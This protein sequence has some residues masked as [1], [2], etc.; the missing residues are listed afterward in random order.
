M[1]KKQNFFR[2]QINHIKS[3]GSIFIRSFGM[4]FMTSS[5]LM[6][7][8]FAFFLFTCLQRIEQAIS[9]NIENLSYTLAQNYMVYDSLVNREASDELNAYMDKIVN[10]ARDF[11]VIAITLRNRQCLYHPNKDLIGKFLPSTIE[12]PGTSEIYFSGDS[13]EYIKQLC[14]TTPIINS[15]NI[16]IGYVMVGI[17]DKAFVRLETDF[18]LKFFWIVI[19]ALLTNAF[20]SYAIA[21][22][23]KNTLFGYEPAHFAQLFIQRSEVVDNMEEGIFAINKAGEIIMCNKPASEMLGLKQEP[24][25]GQSIRSLSIHDKFLTILKSTKPKYNVEITFGDI[26]LMIDWINIKNENES[27]GFVAIIRNKTALTKMAEELTGVNFILE[28][29]RSN[30]HEFKNNLHIILSLLQLGETDLAIRYISEYNSS[31]VSINT[32][33]NNIHDKTIVALI[34]GKINEAREN[35]VILILDENSY[36]PPPPD[37]FLSTSQFTTIIGNLLDNAIDAT[38]GRQTGG[39]ILLFITEDENSLKINIDDN[40]VGIPD[41]NINHIF[42]RGFST[43][44]EN[45]G[46]GLA[47]VKQIIDNYNGTIT[48]HSAEGEGTSISIL[49]GYKKPTEAEKKG[50]FIW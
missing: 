32:V 40:G 17:Y 25:F 1:Q 46:I 10:N 21:Q 43:K 37:P 8:M 47:L 42:T 12:K 22:F 24:V 28:A 36:L 27:I 14:A 29:L 50:K 2:R 48:I 19:L 26:H 38:K 11:D 20:A 3:Q 5:L 13:N 15:R 49:F 31:Q 41:D 6:L 7:I 9:V 44:G 39:Q 35:G 18:I 30:L 45:R 23:V 4:I 34:F 33:V 16:I